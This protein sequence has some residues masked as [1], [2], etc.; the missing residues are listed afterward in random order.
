MYTEFQS[1]GPTTE[2]ALEH[3]SKSLHGI[4]YRVQ[5]LPQGVGEA[6]QRTDNLYSR[7]HSM[8]QILDYTYSSE[9]NSLCSNIL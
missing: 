6:R 7:P 4:S 3:S 8:W 5:Y 2:N 1:L 9:R